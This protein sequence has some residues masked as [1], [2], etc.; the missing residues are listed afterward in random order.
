MKKT[1][2]YKTVSGLL[3]LLISACSLDN[4]NDPQLPF[5][6][7]RLDIPLTSKTI[8]FADILPD[9]MVSKI[10]YDENGEVILYAFQD[11]IPVDSIF[12]D[13]KIAISPFS[14]AI[15]SELGPI[16]LAD[17]PETST[18]PYE[19]IDILPDAANYDQS[20]MPIRPFT[21]RTIYNDNFLTITKYYEPIDFY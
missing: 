4:I 8:T 16:E 3:I 11:T 7:T 17:I 9:S 13:M 12:F 5:W 14:D 6:M 19:F 2:T 15:S 21:L 20:T 18:L 1:P 10:L